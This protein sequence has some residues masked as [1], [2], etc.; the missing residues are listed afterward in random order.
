MRA[1][2]ENLFKGSLTGVPF[3][4]LSRGDAATSGMRFGTANETTTKW[5]RC[6]HRVPRRAR[7]HAKESTMVSAP[8]AVSSGTDGG[9][10]K[11]NA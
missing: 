4:M 9:Q 7:S 2:K 6:R 3:T 1:K 5:A 8:N 10:N 11:A